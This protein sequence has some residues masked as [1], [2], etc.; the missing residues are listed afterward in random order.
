MTLKERELT[1]ELMAELKRRRSQRE[2][3]IVIRHGKIV[4]INQNSSIHSAAGTDNIQFM[5]V[6]QNHTVR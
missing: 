4:T 5:T 2:Q 1:K 6:Y 3:N